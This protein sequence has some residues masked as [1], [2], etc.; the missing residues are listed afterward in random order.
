VANQKNIEP[1]K[2][3]KGTTLNPNGRP[4]GS[5]S[6]STIVKEWLEALI[7]SR[8]PITGKDEKMEVQDKMT[9][10]LINKAFKGDVSAY[11]ELMDAA[12]G[13]LKEQIDH[14]T[15][16]EKL[17]P[18]IIVADNETAELIKELKNTK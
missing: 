1:Y 10:A 18:Q 16:G 5:R 15:G 8:N 13:K 9:L 11:R 4:K 12:H 17:Q 3:K 14:T 7:S 2:M 6:R